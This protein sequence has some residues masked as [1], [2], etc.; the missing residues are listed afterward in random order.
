MI[1]GVS[2]RRLT[3][4]LRHAA[5]PGGAPILSHARRLRS[6]SGQTL[7]EYSLILLLIAL[8]CI[9]ALTV[10]GGTIQDFLQSMAEEI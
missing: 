6:E 1:A 9:S 8:V 5:A 10:I 7:V 4:P 3:A 2:K